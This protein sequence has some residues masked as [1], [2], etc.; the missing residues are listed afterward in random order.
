MR[1]R[2]RQQLMYEEPLIDQKKRILFILT[3]IWWN[4]MEESRSTSN[5]ISSSV[6]GENPGVT[7]PQCQFHCVSVHMCVSYHSD[8]VVEQ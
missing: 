2:L 6:H 8:S 3:T 5:C 1:I 4:M 7:T